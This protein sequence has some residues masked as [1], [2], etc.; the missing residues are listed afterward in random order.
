M[1]ADVLRLVEGY[2]DVKPLGPVTVNEME[3]TNA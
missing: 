3:L 2:V 1:T